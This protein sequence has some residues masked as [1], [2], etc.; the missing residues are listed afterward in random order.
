MMLI[1]IVVA[2][3]AVQPAIEDAVALVLNITTVN[4]V[5]GT[6]EYI[7]IETMPWW[8]LAMAIIGALWMIISSNWKRGGRF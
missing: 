2:Y 8:G 4:V 1:I 3:P 6:L 7:I 5:P